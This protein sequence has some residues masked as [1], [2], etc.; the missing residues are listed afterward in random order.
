MLFVDSDAR[1]YKLVMIHRIV[2]LLR[3]VSGSVTRDKQMLDFGRVIFMCSLAPK[4]RHFWA[5]KIEP[6]PFRT[7]TDGAVF[8]NE[9]FFAARSRIA[10]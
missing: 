5:G 6:Y 4:F 2:F 8:Y 9:I 1:F 10:S 7:L 3:F